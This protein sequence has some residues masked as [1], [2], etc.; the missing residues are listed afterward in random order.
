MLSMAP[1][2]LFLHGLPQQYACYHPKA[3]LQIQCC[4]LTTNILFLTGGTPWGIWW[5]WKCMLVKN[6]GFNSSYLAKYVYTIVF[7]ICIKLLLRL[8]SFSHLSAQ[9]FLPMVFLVYSPSKPHI[10]NLRHAHHCVAGAILRMSIEEKSGLVWILMYVF[11]FFSFSLSLTS[12]IRMGYH[13]S[14][15]EAAP[16]Y[17]VWGFNI[18]GYAHKTIQV[19]SIGHSVLFPTAAKI[20]F[21]AECEVLG[22]VYLFMLMI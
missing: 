12:C 2:P 17:M 6:V 15:S 16:H 21:R 20:W 3:V 9:F 18:N 5:I 10:A 13:L 8:A 22:W 14:T 11:L 1:K 19:F 7:Y 4:E